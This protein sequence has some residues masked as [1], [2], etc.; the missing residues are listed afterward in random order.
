VDASIDRYFTMQRI[1]T[2]LANLI[3]IIPLMASLTSFH[4]AYDG[5]DASPSLI[6]TLRDSCPNLSD[7]HL[8]F[9]RRQSVGFSSHNS[10]RFR[11]LL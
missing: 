3:S 5:V 10:V 8:R 2:L 4:W 6:E 9:G 1:S 7:L 11:C